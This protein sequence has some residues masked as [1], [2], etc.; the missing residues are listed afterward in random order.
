MDGEVV[1]EKT[2]CCSCGSN[3][4]K[5]D[6]GYRAHTM[7]KTAQSSPT[8]TE[9][10]QNTNLGL[11]LSFLQIVRLLSYLTYFFNVGKVLNKTENKCLKL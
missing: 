10:P 1:W 4:T 3:P 8:K 9:V 7:G 11:Q 2:D 6:V 5:R